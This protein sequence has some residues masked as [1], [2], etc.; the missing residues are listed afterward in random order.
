LN[1]FFAAKE[2]TVIDASSPFIV[3][4]SSTR[5]LIREAQSFAHLKPSAIWLV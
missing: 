5:P 1:Y 4:M 2:K 3:R